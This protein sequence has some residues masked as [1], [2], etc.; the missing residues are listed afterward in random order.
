MIL[1]LPLEYQTNQYSRA[2]SE[3]LI[4]S[5]I[6]LVVQ[7]ADQKSDCES[8]QIPMVVSFASSP[9]S[10]PEPYQHLACNDSSSN[11]ALKSVLL[12]LDLPYTAPR[13]GPRRKYHP[14]WMLIALA[15]ISPS[16]ACTF[17]TSCPCLALDG[18]EGCGIR[19]EASQRPGCLSECML[20]YV[21]R[22]SASRLLGRA[23]SACRSF[24]PR[25]SKLAGIR[26]GL[27]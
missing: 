7:H 6:P 17:L 22:L 8:R 26:I 18:P 24:L 16:C 25:S 14:Q 23:L 21:H 5:Y 15:F 12:R 4:S 10:S 20:Y 13:Y 3:S 1:E 27:C 19:F 2:E 9:E 11:P